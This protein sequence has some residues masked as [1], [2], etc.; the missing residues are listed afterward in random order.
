MHGH[1]GDPA[2]NTSAP[3]KH[4]HRHKAFVSPGTTH[5]PCTTCANVNHLLRPTPSTYPPGSSPE[6][7]GG[8]GTDQAVVHRHTCGP[9]GVQ[10]GVHTTSTEAKGLWGAGGGGAAKGEEGGGGR[11]RAVQMPGIASPH[12]LRACNGPRPR[13]MLAVLSIAQSHLLEWKAQELWLLQAHQCG[14]TCPAPLG[15][16]QIEHRSRWAPEAL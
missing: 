11:P 5:V 16:V 14:T 7:G 12:T 15:Q 8:G 13:W 4:T 10:R 2:S 6:V 3:A 9:W 1:S